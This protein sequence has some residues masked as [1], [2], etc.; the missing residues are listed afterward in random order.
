MGEE[1]TQFAGSD[2]TGGGQV[3]PIEG[4]TASVTPRW[5]DNA[6]IPP[7]VA[8]LPFASLVFLYRIYGHFGLE[9]RE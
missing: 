4:V 6:S 7:R 9:K 8:E 3:G 1:A 5:D 2:W